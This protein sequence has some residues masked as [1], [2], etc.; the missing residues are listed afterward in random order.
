MLTGPKATQPR[1]VWDNPEAQALLEKSMV[2][3]A[4]ADRQKIFDELHRRFL[5]EVPFVMLYN[6]IE[7]SAFRKNVQGFTASVLSKPRAWEVR[8]AN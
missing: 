2:T 5:T 3:V 4:Q 8:V 6:G 1:K 7:A